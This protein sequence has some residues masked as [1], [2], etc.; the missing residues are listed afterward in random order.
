MPIPYLWLCCLGKRPR[1]RRSN[2][3]RRSKSRSYSAEY[4]DSSSDG[5]YRD[6]GD[7]KAV[8]RVDESEKI[9]GSKSG[10]G[11]TD[12]GATANDQCD[13]SPGLLEETFSEAVVDK[14]EQSSHHA[15]TTDLDDG[16]NDERSKGNG[17]NSS[18]VEQSKLTGNKLDDGCIPNANVE[19]TALQSSDSKIDVSVE[20]SGETVPN[21]V[22]IA[23]PDKETVEVSHETNDVCP[24]EGNAAT[25]DEPI[26]NFEH[27]TEDPSDT[28][29]DLHSVDDEGEAISRHLQTVRIASDELDLTMDEENPKSFGPNCMSDIYVLGDS[30]T[31]SSPRVSM[32][33]TEDDE[34][35]Y[36]ASSCETFGLTEQDA[37]SDLSNGFENRSLSFDSVNKYTASSLEESLSLDEHAFENEITDAM[38]IDDNNK[39]LLADPFKASSQTYSENGVDQDED[40]YLTKSESQIDSNQK[41]SESSNYVVEPANV[42]VACETASEIQDTFG[43]Q[44]FDQE[45]SDAPT[46][47]MLEPCETSSVIVEPPVCQVEAATY[48]QSD[49][50]KSADMNPSVVQETIDHS[51][52][53]AEASVSSSKLLENVE[54]P[55]EFEKSLEKPQVSDS[56]LTMT[57]EPITDASSAAAESE[58]KSPDSHTITIETYLCEVP[59]PNQP[60]TN[61][62]SLHPPQETNKHSENP[63]EI[64]TEV[65]GQRDV[66]ASV[67]PQPANVA[68]PPFTPEDSTSTPEL[69]SSPSSDAVSLEHD[70]V[71]FPSATATSFASALDLDTTESVA[72]LKEDCNSTTIAYEFDRKCASP[73]GPLSVPVDS[74]NCSLSLETEQI[75]ETPESTSLIPEID[76]LAQSITSTKSDVPDE[77]DYTLPPIVISPYEETFAP[78]SELDDISDTKDEGEVEAPVEPKPKTKKKL[79]S[80]INFKKK[81]SKKKKS[82]NSKHPESSMISSSAPNLRVAANEDSVS[83]ISTAAMTSV[84]HASADS[85]GRYSLSLLLSLMDD[86]SDDDICRE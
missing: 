10:Y 16:G 44:E 30:A 66:S 79:F 48:S 80:R 11:A 74:L 49:I 26:N 43:S 12:D 9:V 70:V 54:S 65:Q 28:N 36:S 39:F 77:K 53:A 83:N 2:D 46:V 52:L 18:S 75:S 8:L 35:N 17:Y 38:A 3:Q 81:N 61:L 24:V 55:F 47:A 78:I 62:E 72:E 37:I 86:L 33:M 5:A 41:A 76:G 59:E 69:E 22:G 13:L 50:Q 71:A 64:L 21:V 25:V 45:T 7:E 19:G 31:Y 23:N 1:P 85:N 15:S 58:V 27:N 51:S 57:L 42:N 4:S 60:A 73:Q 32:I 29:F 6:S 63:C 82:L 68:S 14:D 34:S 20:S 84:S 56:T 40:A 67:P